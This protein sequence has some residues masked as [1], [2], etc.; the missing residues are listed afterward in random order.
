MSQVSIYNPNIQF[1][2]QTDST[3]HIRGLLEAKV[4]EYVPTEHTWSWKETCDSEA[5]AK[6]KR[7]YGIV[8]RNVITGAY[9]AHNVIIDNCI[10]PQLR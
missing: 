8:V 1:L 3:G 4:I 7:V 9:E 2:F 5:E 10:V 6:K